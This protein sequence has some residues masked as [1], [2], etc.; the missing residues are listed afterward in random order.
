[1]LLFTFHLTYTVGN[2]FE[3]NQHYFSEQLELGKS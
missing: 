3:A 1:M 2:Q